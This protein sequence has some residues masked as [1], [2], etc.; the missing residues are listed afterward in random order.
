MID[1]SYVECSSSCITAL[2]EFQEVYPDFRC[3]EIQHAMKKGRAF[4]KNIQ[5][6]D[7]SWY[8]SWGPCFVYATWLGIEGL[9]RSGESLESPSIQKAC[10]F[11]LDHQNPNG[12]WGEDLTS[13]Y[14][15]QYAK[16]GME[17][18][19]DDGSSHVMT[20]WAL[21]ALS[22]AKCPNKEA[23][24]RGVQYIIKR[25]LPSG[26]WSQEGIYGITNRTLGITYANYRN[27]F[28]I[29]ALGRCR[30]VYS[31]SMLNSNNDDD[32]HTDS[33]EESCVT[34]SETTAPPLD[35]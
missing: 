11:M 3:K 2:H 18:Y 15:R 31:D 7:G 16:N 35:Y 6:K 19:G 27:I 24:Q 12:G 28:P 25:Q 9:V 30:A 26:D 1:Y 33:T 23:I 17:A 10:Q 14:D 22:Y 13:C 4:L 5:R 34:T 20:A 21:L 8:G 29:W 32:D